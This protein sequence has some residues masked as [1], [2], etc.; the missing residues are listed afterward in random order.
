[1]TCQRCNSNRIVFISAKSRDLNTVKIDGKEYDGNVPPDIGLGDE[2]SYL[3]MDYCLECG[4]IQGQFPLPESSI[5]TGKWNKDDDED[6]FDYKYG[7]AAPDARAQAVRF[8][9]YKFEWFDGVVV[10]KNDGM[11]GPKQVVVATVDDFEKDPNPSTMTFVGDNICMDFPF[12]L[13]TPF[14]VRF[15]CNISDIDSE[16][17]LIISNAVCKLWDTPKKIEFVDLS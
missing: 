10:E 11:N 16:E 15:K 13:E 7:D 5:E 9:K 3:Q 6:E 8:D 14:K 12:G 4:Q 2:Y 1:M 17:E